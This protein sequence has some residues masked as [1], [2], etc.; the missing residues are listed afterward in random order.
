[1]KAIASNFVKGLLVLVPLAATAYAVYAVITTVDRWL[2]T[3]IPGLGIAITLVLITAVGFLTSNVV[4]RRAVGFLESLVI[5]LPFVKILYG[6][7]KDL[8]GA[9][10]GDKKSFDRPAIVDLGPDGSV[11]A[12]G[13]VTCEKFDDPQLAGHV[14]VYLPQSYNFSGLLVVVPRERVRPID[15][16][17]AHF[18]A[19]VLSGGVATMGAA[20]TVIDDVH[21]LTARKP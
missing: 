4:G 6:S 2:P 18:M 15:A 17:G 13:F 7:L 8:M 3:G 19:F 5:R 20:H 21:Q 14:A 11:K 12:L 9:F 16:D 1:M 10:M